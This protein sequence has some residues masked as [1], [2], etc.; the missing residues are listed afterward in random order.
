MY[1]NFYFK[2]ITYDDNYYYADF[3]APDSEVYCSFRYNRVTGKCE[4]RNNSLPVS[5]IEPIPIWWLD[6]KLAENGMLHKSESKISF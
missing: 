6:K 4:I 1:I 5:S 3:S 2:N